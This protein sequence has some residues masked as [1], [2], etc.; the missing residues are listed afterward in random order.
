MYKGKKII[1]IIPARGGSKGIPRKNIKLLAGKPLIAYTIEVAKKSKLL[2]RIIVSTD[3]KE[4]ASIAK[5]YG[6]EVPFL[7]PKELARDEVLDLPVFQHALKWLEENENYKPEIVLNLRPTN[8]FRT[9]D[10]I[11]NA[12]RKLID[13]NADSIKTLSK[14]SQ[15]PCRMWKLGKGDKLI[16]LKDTEKR[17]VGGSDNRRQDLPRIY[18]QNELVDV[19]RR[20]NIMEK[21]TMFGSD[22]RGLLINRSFPID[23]NTPEDFEIAGIIIKK[24]GGA[25]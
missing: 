21:N 12:I 10:D 7:R 19:C 13:L 11:D 6:S 2:D 9:I 22:R 1:A 14:V 23:L 24:R 8:P 4:I 17:V 16:A 3:D 5:K 25:V 20:S 18:W 15:H